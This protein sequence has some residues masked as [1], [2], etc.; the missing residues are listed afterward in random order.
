MNRRRF[1]GAIAA[2]GVPS[3]AQPVEQVVTLEL[4][5]TT[6]R[7]VVR[8]GI[9]WGE[10]TP[11]ADVSLRFASEDDLTICVRVLGDAPKIT[12]PALIGRG[13]GAIR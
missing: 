7:E 6:V 8:D 13:Q 4:S 11:P 3:A 10:W 12:A 9:V 5:E 1:F 2:V